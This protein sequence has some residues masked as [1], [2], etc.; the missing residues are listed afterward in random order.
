MSSS[1]LGRNACPRNTSKL[2]SMVECGL[3][4]DEIAKTLT[5][6]AEV[7]GNIRMEGNNDESF[8]AEIR[9]IAQALAYRKPVTEDVTSIW[10]LLSLAY[11]DEVNGSEAFRKGPGLS[12]TIFNDV[13]VDESYEWLIVEAPNGQH[14]ES[15]GTIIGA[16][17]FSTDGISRKNGQYFFVE[18]KIFILLLRK[19][20]RFLVVYKFFNLQEKSREDLEP[21]GFL[22]CFLGIVV[23]VLD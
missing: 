8:P 1:I 20:V 11:E 21:F 19:L 5:E 12:K 23:F 4:P 17:C 13:F 10:E 3:S 6:E 15:D 14:V 9:L 7:E 22:V 2:M 18:A 16:C